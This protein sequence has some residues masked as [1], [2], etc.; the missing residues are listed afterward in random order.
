MCIRFLLLLCKF[1]DFQVTVPR[2]VLHL[3]SNVLTLS[4]IVC[5]LCPTLS[6][7]HLLF[8][9]K[10]NIMCHVRFVQ[11]T[12]MLLHVHY[13]QTTAHYRM[14]DLARTSCCQGAAPVVACMQGE[15]CYAWHVIVNAYCGGAATV[16]RVRCLFQCQ[17]LVNSGSVSNCKSLDAKFACP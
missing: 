7:H 13:A 14:S 4:E 16:A 17:V 1:R 11:C 2:R 12:T 10:L 9:N 6:H 3:L 8:E 15:K 5:A